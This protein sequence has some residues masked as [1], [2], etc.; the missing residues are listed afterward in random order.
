[1][2]IRESDL[3]GIGKKFEAI[4]EN[5]D[6][7]VVVIHDDGKREVYHYDDDDEEESIS[8][9]T[10]ND[11]EARQFAAIM[12]GMVY[13]PQALE[14]INVA[15][16]DLIIE[17][18]KVYDE[19]PIAG[20]TIGQLDIRSNFK[21]TIIAIIKK[22]TQNLL[23]PGPDALFEGGDTLIISGERQDVKRIY[24]ELLTKKGE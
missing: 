2:K 14:S 8:G 22:D 13:R 16:N 10:F 11:D 1:M 7:V 24:N 15:F 6:K 19:S 23:S 21:V 5:D 12:G 4:T 18:F 9:V 3:P 17:W 20:K